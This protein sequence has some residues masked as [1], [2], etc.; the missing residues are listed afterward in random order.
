[1]GGDVGRQPLS[2]IEGATA[3]A[4]EGAVQAVIADRVFTQCRRRKVACA[5]LS[6]DQ[7]SEV[8]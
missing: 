6:L 4:S 7:N 8:I 3:A 5:G 2:N 1:M